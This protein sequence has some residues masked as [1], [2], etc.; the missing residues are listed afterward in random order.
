MNDAQEHLQHYAVV[1]WRTGNPVYVGRCLALAAAALGP[2]TVYAKNPRR[3]MA[4]CCAVNLAAETRERDL[5]P[6]VADADETQESTDLVA[7]AP[8]D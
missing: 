8:L 6:L 2:G 1:N 5:P 3:A 4:L 7:A